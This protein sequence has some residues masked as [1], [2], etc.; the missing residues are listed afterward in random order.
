M[1]AVLETWNRMPLMEAATA[2]LPTNGSRAWARGVA[3]RRPFALPEEMFA[4]ADT[5][6]RALQAADWE[7]AFASHPR[8]G[9]GHAG[10][11]TTQSLAWSHAEQSGLGSE[12]ASRAALRE[13]NRAYE[14][15]FGRIF[16]LCAARKG[17]EEVLAV[18]GRR[19]PND[20]ETELLEAAEQ[21]RRITQLRLRRWLGGPGGE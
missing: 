21:Q 11:A 3:L 2:I 16:L 5:V 15:R 9:E 18:L 6:W 19:L 8:L 10:S 20:L 4:A 1:N 13:A 14:A 7:E 12:E 17:A